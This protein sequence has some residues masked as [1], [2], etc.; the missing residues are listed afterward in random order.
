MEN[1]EEVS[2]LESQMYQVLPAA[3]QELAANQCGANLQTTKQQR[4]YIYHRP[5]FV[6]RENLARIS[7]WCAS[8]YLTPATGGGPSAGLPPGIYAYR[9]GVDLHGVY[10][11]PVQIYRV[12]GS[13]L[14][15]S[16]SRCWRSTGR[17]RARLLNSMHDP[18]PTTYPAVRSL[19]KLPLP[20][21]PETR[22][23]S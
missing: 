3:L 2:Q 13:G 22:R 20:L 11:L 15:P 19:P 17:L 4:H 5:P 1:E 10:A 18:S 8:T 16:F 14:S 12:R 9:L 7:E 6:R 23:T 21:R